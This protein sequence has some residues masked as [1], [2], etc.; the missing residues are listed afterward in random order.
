MTE[1]RTRTVAYLRVSTD[2][3]A[4]RGIS[5]EVQRDKVSRY[6]A[7]YDLDLVD[8]VEDAGHS[9][10][11]LDRPGLQRA[12]SMLKSKDA[13]A[14]LVVRLDRLT[15]SVRDLGALVESTF[16]RSA[17]LSV[18]EQIDTRTAAGRL[19]LNVLASVAQWEREAIAERTSSAM[20]HMRD[21]RRFTGGQP[22]FGFRA[23]DSGA[24]VED[25]GEQAIVSEVRRLDAD[26]LSVPEIAASLA[27][28]GHVSRAGRPLS[29][30]QV[31]RIVASAVR[32]AITT[33]GPATPSS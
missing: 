19:V 10:K 6:A 12:L 31:R 25:A 27:A 3:Q 15:R 7:L 9:G 30:T 21:N 33:A 24:L 23:L 20:R 18:S 32:D 29:R 28:A 14:L 16:N 13:D 5:L 2:K 22:P 11:S 4:D 26:G 8:V 1:R 17:L